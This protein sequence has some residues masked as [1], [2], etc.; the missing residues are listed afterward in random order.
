[1]KSR[2]IAKKSARFVKF[3]EKRKRIGNRS[4]LNSHNFSDIEDNV[5][6]FRIICN[7][8]AHA[9]NN[10]SAEAK[11][12]GVA[13]VYARNNNELVKILGSGEVVL[14]SPKLKR[15]SF[16]IKYNPFTVLNAVKK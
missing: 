16:Y 13:R 15:A 11:A 1:M 4:I 2:Q 5:N 12:A 3:K 7:L 10:A 9:G 14:I 8:A 6:A